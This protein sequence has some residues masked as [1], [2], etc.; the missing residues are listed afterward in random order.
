VVA[1]IAA[2]ITYG[3]LATLVTGGIVLI[4]AA[5][6]GQRSRTYEAAVLKTL[7]ASRA[8]ILASFAL[9]SALLGAAAGLVAIV[10]G[11]AAAWAVMVFVMDSKFVF[12]PAS[13]LAIVVGGV[14]ATLLAGL[15]FAW[16]P[17]SARPARVLRSRE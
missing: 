8:T 7:G 16:W 1:G 9:R 12:E 4:G 14:S 13:A 3:A 10:A 6:A 2:A 5:A 11:G 17:L 15:A